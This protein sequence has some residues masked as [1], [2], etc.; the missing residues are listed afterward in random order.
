LIACVSVADINVEES[1][2]TLRYASRARS[3]TQ[4]VRKNILQSPLSAHDAS[5]LRAENQHLKARLDQYEGS[6]QMA[7]FSTLQTKLFKAEQEAQRAREH[8]KSVRRTADKWK[9]QFEKIKVARKVR[10]QCAGIIARLVLYSFASLVFCIH[11][12]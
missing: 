10:L 8:A 9:E 5:F 7:E 6:V 12:E 4:A 11:S 2:H 3:I 1:L